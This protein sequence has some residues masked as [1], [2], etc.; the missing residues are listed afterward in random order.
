MKRVILRFAPSNTGKPHLG[1]LK[2]IL[3][4]YFTVLYCKNLYKDEEVKSK[5]FLRI[6]DTDLKRSEEKYTKDILDLLDYFKIDYDKDNIIY[7]SKRFDIYKSKAID[8]VKRGLAFYC[9]CA[10]KQ[11]GTIITRCS[12]KKNN[13][14]SGAIKLYI[15]KNKEISWNDLI[16]G[17]ITINTDNIPDTFIL[18][19]EGTPTYNFSV[20]IDDTE[21]LY[22]LD[23]EP[24]S[25]THVIRGSE[26]ITNTPKQLIII[27]YL[28]QEPPLYGH[29]PVIIKM[30]N[31]KL[32]KRDK[33][34]D[35][36]YY[37][38]E[39]Y[40]PE[41][42]V[43]Y[44]LS[45][46]SKID[47]L[48][49]RNNIDFDITKVTKSPSKFDIKK[50]LDLS[51]KHL[52][53]L[54]NDT[55]ECL[56]KYF[57]KR[58]ILLDNKFYKLLP[59]LVK[60]SKTFKEVL[61]NSEF[62]RTDSKYLRTDNTTLIKNIINLNTDEINNLRN[63]LLNIS[64]TEDSIKDLFKNYPDTHSYTRALRLIIT[65]S[66]ISPPLIDIILS[67]GIDFIKNKIHF[68]LNNL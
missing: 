56:N 1:T 44:I 32:S 28:K 60:R 18:K 34:G 67:C 29:L 66:E 38:E 26:H 39:G 12:C 15:E 31:K 49:D 10:P 2:T 25:I 55:L 64:L 61:L 5:L 68:F 46:G 53:L 8:L 11:E 57:I 54:S 21:R 4:N 37:I 52:K 6:E 59:E 30:D 65:G 22:E 41:S 62:L 24:Y 20:S 40:V 35:I 51:S 42:I 63:S 17:R 58:N 47:Y 45:L 14:D 36:Y 13:Y 16:L 27:N 50:L 23:N 3:Y 19:E 33:D 9:K 48:A 43:N 7:Q